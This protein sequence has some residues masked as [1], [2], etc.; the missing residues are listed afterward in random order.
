MTEADVLLFRAINGAG[1][2][3]LEP[4]MHALSWLGDY[5]RLPLYAGVLTIVAAWCA[6]RQRTGAASASAAAALRLVIGVAIAAPV[7]A[8]LKQALALSRPADALDGVHVFAA[9]GSQFS[10]PSGHSAFAALVAATLWPLLPAW[11]RPAA[12]LFAGGVAL[13]RLW[14]GV[15]FPSDVAAGL[16]IGVGV[17]AWTGWLAR[18]WSSNKGA[19][20]GLGLATLIALLDAGSETAIAAAL[21]PGERVHISAFLNM[22]YLGNPGG[23]DWEWLFAAGALAIAAWLLREIFRPGARP[24]IKAAYGVLLGGT[25]ASLFD[26]ALRGG[27][28]DWLDLHWGAHHWPLSSGDGAIVAGAALLL[29]AMLRPAKGSPQGRVAPIHVHT[30]D[31]TAAAAALFIVFNMASGR[32]GRHDTLRTIEGVLSAAGRPWELLEVSRASKLSQA[33]A[34]AVRLA[35]ERNGAAVAAGGDGTINA[36]AQAVLETGEAGLPFGVLP[37]GTFNYFARDN[38]IPLEMPAALRV[39]LAGRLRPVQVGLVNERAFLVNASLGFYRRLLEDREAF[40]QRYGRERWIALLS[41]L[42]SLTFRE[43]RRFAVRVEHGGEASLIRASTLFIGNNALQLE[44]V[45]IPEASELRKGRLVAIGVRP[46]SKP[47]MLGLALRGA[48]RSLAGA[49]HAFRFTFQRMEVQR[50]APAAGARPVKVALDGETLR[51]AP[52]LVFRVGAKPLWLLSPAQ[53]AGTQQ[54]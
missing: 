44:E 24:A 13:S 51:I 6:R 40:K 33:A 28:V 29:Y 10:F 47:V 22:A 35:Q 42:W 5:W 45:G 1:P 8:T 41:A 17:A 23:E 26:R 27:A 7:T 2:A 32:R 52:P 11:G 48:T 36:V 37:L 43:Q 14:L 46:A 38:A 53:D 20:L 19:A 21:Q 39:L 50:V 34:R 12:L 16:L 18:R 49:E 3:A 15:H 54:S 4:L 31:A 9:P 25:L 30:P